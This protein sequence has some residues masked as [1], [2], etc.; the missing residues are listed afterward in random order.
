MGC[1]S[2]LEKQVRQ[3]EQ[4]HNNHDIETVMSLYTG[5]IRFEITGSWFRTGKEQV[6]GLAEWDSVTH[7]HMAISQIVVHEDTVHFKLREGNDWFRLAG[8]EN[9]F[10][11]PCIMVFSGGKI[12]EIRAEVARESIL[13]FQQVWPSIFRWLSENRPDE[14]RDLIPEG[15]FVYN[16]SS[17]RQWL[18]LLQEWREQSAGISGE[19]PH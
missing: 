16:A 15:E 8:I 4:A 12:K 18:S 9:M 3:Y 14:M 17:A 13:E 11:D 5:D 7:S 10:Y 19:S 6:R 1:G 2:G